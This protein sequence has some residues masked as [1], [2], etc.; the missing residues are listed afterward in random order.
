LLS[1]SIGRVVRA[2]ARVEYGLRNVHEALDT[3]SS[4]DNVAAGF[5]GADRLVNDC[6]LRLRREVRGMDAPRRPPV[7]PV[8]TWRDGAPISSHRWTVS[9]DLQT[10]SWAP[11]NG[12]GETQVFH[13]AWGV[14]NES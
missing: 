10:M 12:G 6:M 4:T 13:A 5:V 3:P 1:L 2:H 8:G 7:E 14:P 11:G 9:S